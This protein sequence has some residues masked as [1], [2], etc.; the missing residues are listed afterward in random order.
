MGRRNGALRP[1]DVPLE[2]VLGR[3]IVALGVE[4]HAAYLDGASVLVTGAGGSLG[5]ELCGRVVRLGARELVLLDQSEAGLV[6][7]ADSLRREQGFAH[8]V[9]VLADVTRAGRANEVFERHRPDVV[10]HAAAYK[11]VPLLEDHPVEGV[12]ANI[13]GTRCVVDAALR[14]GVGRFVLFSTDKAVE[15]TSVLGRTK[16]VAEWIVAAAGRESR[17]RYA[18]VRLGNVI[19]ST[20]SV[21]PIF[22]RQ[23]AEAG[24]VTVTHPHA[25]RYVCTA[26]EAAELA[27]VAGALADSASI[28]WL[29]AGPPVSVVDLARRLAAAVSAEIVV[30]FVGL[31]PGERVHEQM[32]WPS[33]QAFPT[34]CAQVFRSALHQVDAAW[35]DGWTAAL[36][37]YV[38]R[39][40]GAGVRAALAEMHATVEPDELRSAA[41]AR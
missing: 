28:F 41:V 9:P 16:A 19:D 18:A 23:I 11:H 14:F 27:I 22:R 37:G 26:G 34:A 2:A 33:E 38:E 15:P 35:L 6:A 36:A 39:A 31:R 29:D 5:A 17:G 13:L 4:A 21:L 7:L 20:G 24:P 8:A 30:D 25:T 10:F 32:L 40:S 3:P 1:E 12:S